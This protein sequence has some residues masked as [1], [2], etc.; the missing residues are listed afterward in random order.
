MDAL[1]TCEPL[2]AHAPGVPDDAPL[3]GNAY[4]ADSL[5]SNVSP[6]M[7]AARE[8][9]AIGAWPF[10]RCFFDTSPA[11]LCGAEAPILTE[12]LDQGL[13]APGRWERRGRCSDVGASV[14]THS[15]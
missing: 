2:G 4:F 14:A 6:G 11:R 8:E 7:S 9:V 1:P 15:I 13:F 5:L 12:S 10:R 3:F